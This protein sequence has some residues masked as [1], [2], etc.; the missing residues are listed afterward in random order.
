MKHHGADSII[1][2]RRCSKWHLCRLTLKVD[3]RN[4]GSC[5]GQTETNFRNN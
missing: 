2:Q 4:L 1:R 3:S 5:L